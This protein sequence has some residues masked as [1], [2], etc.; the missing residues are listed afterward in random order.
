MTVLATK[1]DYDRPA[2]DLGDIGRPIIVGFEATG[3]YH[4]TLAHRL[5]GGLRAATDFVG[6]PGSHPRGIAQW[7]GQERSQGCA[8]DPACCGSAPPTLR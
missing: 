8:G 6:C 7:L 3:N 1:A 5:L 2:T 4:R